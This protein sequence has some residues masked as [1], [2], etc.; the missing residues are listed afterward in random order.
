MQGRGE[1]KSYLL[2][3]YTFDVVMKI[4]NTFPYRE[5]LNKQELAMYRTLADFLSQ[6]C[7]FFVG[8]KSG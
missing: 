5:V 2:A 4:S 3:I 7:I 1:K 6:I 8:V